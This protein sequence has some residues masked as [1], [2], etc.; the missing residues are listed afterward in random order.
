MPKD[1]GEIIVLLSLF[2]QLQ[3]CAF[4]GVWV[5]QVYYKTVY[6]AILVHARIIVRTIAVGIRCGELV[7]A[8]GGC[9]ARQRGRFGK[10]RQPSPISRKL[11]VSLLEIRNRFGGQETRHREGGRRGHPPNSNCPRQLVTLIVTMSQYI[12]RNTK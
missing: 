9:A 2:A 4:P 1:E 11:S 7:M 12:T 3:Q 10:V 8:L 5:H 6:F